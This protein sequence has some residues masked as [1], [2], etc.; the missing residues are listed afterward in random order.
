MAKSM[1]LG[2]G[3]RFASL[4]KRVE[5]EGYSPESAGAITASIG[6]KKYGEKKMSEMSHHSKMKKVIRKHR[7][8]Y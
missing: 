3:G 4:K 1:R 6:R 5:G 8:S 7:G 2:G